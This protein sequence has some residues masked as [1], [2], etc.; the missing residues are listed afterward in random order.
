MKFRTLHW[1]V[2]TFHGFRWDSIDIP[3]DMTPRQV[4]D[5]IR[6]TN[7]GLKDQPYWTESGIEGRFSL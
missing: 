4:W 7:P 5:D 2:V 3:F 1:R 6:K